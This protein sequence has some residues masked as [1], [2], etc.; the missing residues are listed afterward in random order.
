MDGLIMKYFVL[1][2]KAK[3]KFDIYAKASQQAMIAY[4]NCIQADNNILAMELSM[5]AR[6][7][8]KKM[9]TLDK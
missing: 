7:E 4:A 3:S 2:P 8:A 9:Q 1:K 5:W 6:E